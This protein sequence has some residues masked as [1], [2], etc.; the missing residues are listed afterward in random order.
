MSRQP[1]NVLVYPFLRGDDGPLFL[2]LRRSDNGIW[3]GVSGG[4]EG[5][6]SSVEAAMRELTE[7]LGLLDP[8]PVI[9][10]TMYSGARRTA[11]SV[12]HIWPRNVYIV[13]K[14]FFAVDLS[15][16]GEVVTLSDEHTECLWLSYD[17]AHE[18][19]AYSDERTGLWELHQRILADD[20]DAGNGAPP[21]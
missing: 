18:R 20:L 6:E 14:R 15:P 19:I 21:S 2:I 3:Q 11:F 17:E 10:L 4:V 16:L 13:E 5:E 8:P 7:E 9:P 12:H 1:R